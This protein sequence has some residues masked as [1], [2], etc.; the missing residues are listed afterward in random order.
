MR[1]CKY[2]WLGT[3]RP[4]DAFTF[5]FVESANGWYQAHCY[6]FAAGWST[7]IVETTEE[8]WRAD[9]LEQASGE[10]TIA[11]CE[12]L[13]GAHL[14]GHRLVS[15]AEH[16][17]GSAAWLNFPRVNCARWHLNNIVLLGDAAATA[18]FSVG[19]GTRRAISASRVTKRTGASK[20]CGCRMRRAIRR[21]GSSRW[22]S[23]P[24]SIPSSSTTAW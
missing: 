8:V 23:R 3:H 12:K 18:H 4:F 7:F 19:S 21:N 24:T 15:N 5:Y 11:F 9:G 20:C 17:R 14:D 13:F 22:P 16:L 2:I 10:Q 6:P 1:A